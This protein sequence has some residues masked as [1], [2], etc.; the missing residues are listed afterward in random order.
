MSRH[1]PAPP[2][3]ALKIGLF[4]QCWCRV[5]QPSVTISVK[6][7]PCT[8]LKIGLFYQCWCR[9]PQPSVTISVK[10]SPCTAL[11]I[12]LFYQC[13]CRVPQ[14]SVTISVKTSS[15]TALNIGLFYQCWCT[16]LQQDGYHMPLTVAQEHCFVHV[17]R[18]IEYETKYRSSM[19][20]VL[21]FLFVFGVLR[22]I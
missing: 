6:T 20:S 10:T 12:G 16:C 14:P 15:C 1:R 2:C 19:F 7:S 5:P 17:C 21:F 22:S 3:T 9:V 18:C 11:K 4:Y 8:A 13:W